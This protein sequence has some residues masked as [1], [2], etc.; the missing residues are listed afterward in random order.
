ML[1]RATFR[2]PR[3][4][5]RALPLPLLLPLFIPAC[6]DTAVDPPD[7]ES[8]TSDPLDDADHPSALE[9]TSSA[10]APQELCPQ[11]DVELLPAAPA[12]LRRILQLDDGLFALDAD[13]RLVTLDGGAWQVLWHFDAATRDLWGTSPE[14]LLI[15]IDDWSAASG[16]HRFSGGIAVPMPSQ[17][18]P[19]L[20]RTLHLRA[21]AGAGAERWAAGSLTHP[22]CEGPE[23]QDPGEIPV[24]LR[25][26]GERWQI[27]RQAF[28]GTAVNDLAWVD[29]TL[30][31]VTDAALVRL[32]DGAWHDTPA[33][34]WD[35]PELHAAAPDDLFIAQIGGPG[36]FRSDG[37]AFTWLPSRYSTWTALA[38]R[39]PLLWFSGRD[40]VTGGESV[41]R[42][43]GRRTTAVL[44]APSPTLQLQAIPHGALVLTEDGRLR[45]L[46]GPAA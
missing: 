11:P 23:C 13:D 39:G 18:S 2:R 5:P 3:R 26:D 7:T 19:E 37:D 20:R 14:D 6:V 34:L 4:H 42:F 27:V 16:V 40:H 32:Q 12:P 9:P 45:R 8:D 36:L 46:R 43:D 44:D 24:L 29:G 21:L 15:A 25:D 38:G 30:V 31:A 33:N 17:V 1:P 35:T 41:Y 10:L 28:A 22:T